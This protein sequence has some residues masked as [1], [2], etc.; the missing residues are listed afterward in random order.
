MN[1]SVS[2]T[3]VRYLN[4]WLLVPMLL[5][6][7]GCKNVD[8]QQ[9]ESVLKDYQRPLDNQTIVAGLKQAL[10]I[11][12]SNSV[13]QTSQEGGYFNNPLIKIALP[14]ELE[15]PAKTLRK[16][17][18]GSYVDSFEKQMNRAAES[19]S[20]EAK[21]VFYNSIRQMTISD[22]VSIL[23]GPDNAATS[24]FR[25]V[26]ESQLRNKFAPIVNQSMQK[27]GFY[28]DYRNLLKTYDALPL[29]DK[30]NLDIEQHILDKSLDG[31]FLL[32][33]E[34]EKKIR[35]NPAA[36]VTELLRRVFAG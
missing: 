16:F 24:Y 14:Q 27:V 6:T 31:L 29:T 23:R 28:Q 12:T 15:K 35:D 30:P 22:A 4:F 1:S 18:L 25:R 26:N 5:L 21:Q 7:I 2:T 17:G 13:N 36:R 34:E 9:V 19:A 3:M 20:K 8:L 32:V 33:A 11:G 10:E